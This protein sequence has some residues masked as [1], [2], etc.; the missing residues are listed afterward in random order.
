[1]IVV[2]TLCVIAGLVVWR[3]RRRRRPSQRPIPQNVE[4]AVKLYRELERALASSGHARPTAVTPA[5]H[6]RALETRG[7]PCASE[8]SEV[9]ESYMRVRYGGETIADPELP[10]LRS[11]VARVRKAAATPAANGGAP[12]TR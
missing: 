5:E 1:L 6:A 2:L 3:S 9:T 8:V 11:A 4:Q 10:R 12:S 7:F